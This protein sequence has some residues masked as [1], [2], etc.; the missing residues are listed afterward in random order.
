MILSISD[1]V[2]VF[3]WSVVCGAAI[4]FVYDLFRIFRKAI[5][6]GSL[7]TFVQDVLYWLITSVIMFLTSYYSN[8]GELRG[9]LFLGALIGAVLYALMFSRLIMGS[10][11]F[12]IRV[13]VKIVRFI[14][15]VVSYPFRMVFR[16]LVI[17]T[18]K[19]AKVCARE[20][21]RARDNSRAK[22]QARRQARLQA[23]LQA[24][25]QAK[26]RV[27]AKRQARVEA[28]AQAKTMAKT[29]RQA[30]GQAKVQARRQ[31]KTEAKVQAKTQRQGPGLK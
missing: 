5:K 9:F 28:K 10:S 17:P 30:K 11:L 3:L 15:F 29:R 31:A 4:A 8:D 12:I 1:Q 16:L 6:T 7:V 21:R 24:K 18:R 20:L 13:T 2:I 22:A 27:I 23:R 14:S 25:A 19:L 26:A